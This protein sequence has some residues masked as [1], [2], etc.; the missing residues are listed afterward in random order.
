MEIPD[1]KIVSALKA[2]EDEL[3]SSK[4]LGNI[5]EGCVHANKASTIRGIGLQL[6]VFT[7]KM[8]ADAVRRSN[9]RV[10]K[11]KREGK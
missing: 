9:Y 11:M 5:P 4:C 1:E 8:I 2:Y 6:G 7:D 10:N 3:V